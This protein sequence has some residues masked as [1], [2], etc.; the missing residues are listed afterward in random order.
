[1]AHDVGRAIAD[2]AGARD[3]SVSGVPNRVRVHI[4]PTGENVDDIELWRR[5]S[6]GGAF[7]EALQAAS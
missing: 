4:D 1:L 6:G 7:P 2:I 5:V 3:T